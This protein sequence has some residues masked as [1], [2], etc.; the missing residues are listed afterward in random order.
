M[1][2]VNAMAVISAP[3]HVIKCSGVKEY[4]YVLSTKTKQ[5]YRVSWFQAPPEEDEDKIAY[6]NDALPDCKVL[7]QTFSGKFK[8]KLT[9]YYLDDVIIGP[10]DGIIL[11]MPDAIFLQ[12]VSHRT[13]T[14]DMVCFFKT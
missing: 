13:K 8:K 4:A 2:Q 14:F 9:E 12:R 5:Y 10:E 3:T 1:I 7:T 11:D 6:I